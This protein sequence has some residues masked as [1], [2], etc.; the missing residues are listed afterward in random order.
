MN[1]P[2][3]PTPAYLNTLVDCLA[4]MR[5]DGFKEDFS[6][7]DDCLF[8]LTT[9]KSYKAEDVSIVNFFR[10]EG[11]TDP[12][13]DS[14]MYVILTRDGSKG[15]LIDGYGPSSEP[16]TSHFILQVQNMQKKV[17]S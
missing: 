4:K 10:F 2:A 11:Q 15:T 7:K 9:G 6:I 13:D 12:G 1:T 8:S 16:E 14:I 5:E 3:A 17:S